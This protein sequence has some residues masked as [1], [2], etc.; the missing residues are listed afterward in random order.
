MLN[1]EGAMGKAAR[2][3]MR[4]KRR[5]LMLTTFLLMMCITAFLCMKAVIE[6]NIDDVSRMRAEVLV[7]RTVNRALTEQFQQEEIPEE[8]FI[9]SRDENGKT[10]LVQANSIEIN[11]LMTRLVAN[12]QE[13]FRNMEKEPL[14]VPVGAFLGSKLLSQTGPAVELYITPVSV[15]STDFR[16]E[17][18]SQGI[19]QTKY[20]IYIVLECRVKVLAPFSSRSFNTSTDV[21]IAETVILGEV[22][23]SYVQVPKEDILDVTD[24]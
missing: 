24:E 17:F 3:R 21:L 14:D 7:S 19:N 5:L 13:A 18:E 8:L 2:Q 20:K 12:L 9:I 6:P 10:A 1:G 23:G 16:T 15:L 22:P 4:L 11:I